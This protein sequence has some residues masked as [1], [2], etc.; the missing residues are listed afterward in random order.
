G[1][2]ASI[3]LL[4]L[5][6][7]LVGL[8]G[9]F[10]GRLIQAAVSRQREFLADASAVQFTR[11]PAGITGALKKIG[12]STFGSRLAS[13]HATESSHLFFANALTMA[14]AGPWA[15]HPPLL[16]RIRATEPSFDGRFPAVA[17]GT[18]V[19]FGHPTTA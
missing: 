8:I 7:I 4:G 13:A 9:V 18:G 17:A 12:G 14:G 1:G 6:I 19:D 3:A 16:E 15:T 2:Q 5:A 10:F 11:N